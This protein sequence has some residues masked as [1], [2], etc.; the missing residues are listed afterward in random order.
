MS[1]DLSSIHGLLWNILIHARGGHRKLSSR[2]SRVPNAPP[3][4]LDPE[5]NQQTPIG[6]SWDVIQN[7]FLKKDALA[8]A[9]E[10]MH[11]PIGPW[12]SYEDVFG[13]LQIYALDHTT[14]CD[15][16]TFGSFKLVLKGF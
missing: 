13:E 1:V 7:L 3:R 14:P 6:R 4:K 16:D 5:F 12:N 2:R 11:F 8:K 10:S 15:I 9:V